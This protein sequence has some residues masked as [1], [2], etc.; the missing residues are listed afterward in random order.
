M[1]TEEPDG[2]NLLVRIWRGPGGETLPATLQVVGQFRGYNIAM[3]ERHC[4]MPLRAALDESRACECAKPERE[5][6]PRTDEMAP[7]RAA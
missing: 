2:G 1:T 3:I 7:Q 4:A 6:F 5:R